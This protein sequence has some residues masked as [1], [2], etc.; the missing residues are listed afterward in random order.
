M[1]NPTFIFSFIFTY[2][3]SSKL[4]LRTIFPQES[5]QTTHVDR[6]LFI[7]LV[8]KKR[9]KKMKKVYGIQERIFDSLSIF[10]SFSLSYFLRHH[11]LRI[12]KFNDAFLSST[13]LSL[14]L[15]AIFPIICILAQT[16]T[17]KPFCNFI[18]VPIGML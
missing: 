4:H 15:S 8:E 12:L 11:R 9:E 14:S 2:Y 5:F 6:Q 3:I 18:K 7:L 16:D 10:S 13:S 1:I 17:S